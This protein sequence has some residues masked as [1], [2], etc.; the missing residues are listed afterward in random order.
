MMRPNYISL[1]TIINHK[2]RECTRYLHFMYWNLLKLNL[3]FPTYQCQLKL[4]RQDLHAS[5]QIFL[6]LFKVC[7]LSRLIII[8]L[9]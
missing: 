5:S 1:Y 4:A 3:V 9:S 7:S 2:L 6:M 8:D